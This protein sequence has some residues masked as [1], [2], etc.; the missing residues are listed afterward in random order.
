[1]NMLY[2]PFALSVSKGECG[3][4]VEGVR[5]LHSVR[6]SHAVRA[7]LVEAWAALPFDMLRA[8]GGVGGTSFGKL[9]PKHGR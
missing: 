5:D 1:M 8:N 3:V 7:E 4:T 9:S 2:T 6:A